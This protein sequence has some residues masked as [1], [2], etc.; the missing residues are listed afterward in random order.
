MRFPLLAALILL[1]VPLRAARAEDPPPRVQTTFANLMNSLQKGDYQGLF[2]GATET[3]QKGLTPQMAAAVT[4][5]LAPRM[6]EGYSAQFLTSQRKASYQIYL[7]KL[8]FHDEKD[9]LLAKVV[10]DKDGRVAG[11]WID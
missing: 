1:A 11:F 9:D 6:N 4:A 10:I 3:F 8:S 2:I 5:Q 7:W